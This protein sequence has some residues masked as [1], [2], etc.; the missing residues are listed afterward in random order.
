[1]KRDQALVTLSRDHHDGLLLAVRLQQGK[2]ALLRLWSHDPFWQAKYVVK[3]YEDHLISHFE[4]EE[5]ILF[6][7]VAQYVKDSS[8]INKLVEEH[9]EM[10]G[11]VDSFRHPEEK[12]LECNLEQFGKLLESHIRCEERELFPL[13]EESIPGESLREAQALIDQYRPQGGK[14]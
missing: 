12:K 3:F 1:M 6:P 11:Y 8:V 5:K 9:K 13:C 14:V 7:L 4:A 10:R 2:K